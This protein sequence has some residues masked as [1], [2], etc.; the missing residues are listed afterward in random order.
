M[1]SEG[2][3]CNALTKIEA[4]LLIQQGSLYLFA[5]GIWS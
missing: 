2:V 3:V 5:A 1:L 4:P